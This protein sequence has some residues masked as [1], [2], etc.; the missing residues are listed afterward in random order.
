VIVKQLICTFLY[1]E[2]AEKVMP[3]AE[4]LDE[5]RF[6]AMIGTFDVSITRNSSRDT[7]P[8]PKWRIGRFPIYWESQFYR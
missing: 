1:C 2:V 5:Q 3:V 4:R 6:G 8:E 7:N